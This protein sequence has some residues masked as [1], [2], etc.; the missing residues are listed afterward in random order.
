MSPIVD[1]H[2]ASPSLALSKSGGNG[3]PPAPPPTPT[4]RETGEGGGEGDLACSDMTPPHL[5]SGYVEAQGPSDEFP[6]VPSNSIQ[7][8]YINVEQSY[9]TA[10]QPLSTHVK[11]PQ[12]LL[13][14]MPVTAALLRV[15]KLRT[16]S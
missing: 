10:T 6:G 14:T 7:E 3:Q 13:P 12:R 8:F 5:E 4:Q 16:Q 1:T 11:E 15:A 9:D 2:P